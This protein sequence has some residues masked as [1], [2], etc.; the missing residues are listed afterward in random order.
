MQTIFQISIVQLLRY[1][2]VAVLIIGLI[3]IITTSVV[4]AQFGGAVNV[5]GVLSGLLETGVAMLILYTL[6]YILSKKEAHTAQIEAK[7]REITEELLSDEAG[8]E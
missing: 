5:G 8:E 7:T 2:M 6:S 1:M 3:L 4:V